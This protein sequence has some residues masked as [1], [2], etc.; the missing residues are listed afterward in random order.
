MAVVLE[1]TKTKNMALS[2]PGGMV[3]VRIIYAQTRA[4]C[5]DVGACAAR[6]LEIH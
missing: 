1:S 2:K 5:V 4:A 3:L 6:E